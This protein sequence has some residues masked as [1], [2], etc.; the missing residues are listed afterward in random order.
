MMVHRHLSYLAIQFFTTSHQSLSLAMLD[1]IRKV[2]CRSYSHGAIFRQASAKGG[3]FKPDLT[4]K[5]PRLRILTLS[6][7]V[8]ALP[9]VIPDL[10]SCRRSGGGALS[11]DLL[12]GFKVRC[13]PKRSDCLL[14]AMEARA[15]MSCHAQ[16]AHS[17]PTINTGVLSFP[18][19]ELR[20]LCDAPPQ[21]SVAPLGSDV[22][23][24]AL[25]YDSYLFT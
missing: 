9:S 15:W 11:L 16:S 13:D 2:D 23:P 24:A 3:T 8:M 19:V 18:N 1:S 25:A 7:H 5:R 6:S 20:S 17:P 12:P 22:P 4:H 21:E 14:Q 10:G